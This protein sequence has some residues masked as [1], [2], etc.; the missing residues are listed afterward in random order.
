MSIHRD[1]QVSVVLGDYTKFLKV[2]GIFLNFEKVSEFLGI[3]GI[4]GFFM[5]FRK[6]LRVLRNFQEFRAVSISNINFSGYF[7]K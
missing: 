6:F 2:F 5:N 7:E 1:S 3:S 4:L